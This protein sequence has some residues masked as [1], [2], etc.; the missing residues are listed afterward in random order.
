METSTNGCTA[1]AAVRIST[2][3][4]QRPRTDRISVEATARDSEVP[5][6]SGRAHAIAPHVMQ[7]PVRFAIMACGFSPP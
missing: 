7:L 6:D 5:E 2:L 4:P 1:H 3:R